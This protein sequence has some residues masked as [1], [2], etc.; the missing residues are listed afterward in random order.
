MFNKEY[1]AMNESKMKEVQLERLRWSLRHAYE[2]V[3]LY[4]KKFDEAGFHPDQFKSLDDMK[5]VPFLE[6]QNMRDN[7]PFGLFAVP[8][9]KVARVHS[10]SG[11]T[12]NATVV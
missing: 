4:K 7:Y 12:G 10:S 11:T 1:E 3:P 2:N 9:E 6:K 8:L 5:R